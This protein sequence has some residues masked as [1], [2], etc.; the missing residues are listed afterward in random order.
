[1]VTEIQALLLAVL[2]GKVKAHGHAIGKELEQRRGNPVSVGTLY[3]GLHS[4]ERQGYV[5]SKWEE[6]LNADYG[7]PRRRFYRINGAGERALTEYRDHIETT[8]RQL[9][10]RV[11]EAQA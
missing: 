9:P 6:Q 10:P 7:R 8:L 5:H 2:V 11:R 1:M 3:K 4:L